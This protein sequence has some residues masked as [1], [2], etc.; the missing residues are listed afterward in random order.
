[1][2]AVFFTGRVCIRLTTLCTLNVPSRL[3]CSN[4]Q[5]VG[6][7]TNLTMAEYAA[8]QPIAGGYQINVK[9]HKTAAQG[10]AV[11]F[12]TGELAGLLE[13]YSAV[14]HTAL[15][16]TDDTFFCLPGRGKISKLSARLATLG[17]ACGLKLRKD[18]TLLSLSV[19]VEIP[20]RPRCGRASQTGTSSLQVRGI[21]TAPHSHEPEASPAGRPAHRISPASGAV[22][23]SS[24]GGTNAPERRGDV[25]DAPQRLRPRM[26]RRARGENGA[27]PSCDDQ[28]SRRPLDQK[29]HFLP[30]DL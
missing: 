2:P 22:P 4:S 19:R 12:A 24:R 8:R 21:A 28:T 5:R 18:C 10:P 27:R 17:K 9:Q 20:H 3:S 29:S 25:P 30:Q 16:P 26:E 13:D 23:S 1:M 7:V 11:L 15:R 6:A 14:V